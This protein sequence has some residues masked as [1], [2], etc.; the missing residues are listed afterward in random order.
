ELSKVARRDQ[1]VVGGRRLPLCDA[2]KLERERHVD[3]A[4]LDGVVAELA[5]LGVPPGS[6]RAPDVFLAAGVPVQPDAI[7][8][9][10]AGGEAALTLVG[11][12]SFDRRVV[13]HG[14]ADFRAVDVPVVMEEEPNLPLRPFVVDLDL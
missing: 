6:L 5:I 9:L 10:A 2:T 11:D 4:L 8:D 14:V 1:P 13:H 7:T 12:Q 3:R